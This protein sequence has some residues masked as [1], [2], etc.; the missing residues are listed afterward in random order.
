MALKFT[1]GEVPR[2]KAFQFADLAELTILV[3]RTS[4]VSKADLDSLIG[5]GSPDSDPDSDGESVDTDQSIDIAINHSK[6]TEDCFKQFSYRAGALDDHY[7]FALNNSL[8]T[9]KEN[10]TTSGYIYLFCLVCSRL[11][12]FSGQRGFAQRCAKAFTDLSSSAMR[13]V[14]KQSADVYVFD[15]GSKD[16]NLYFHTDLRQALKK[17]A[18][19]LNALPIHDVIDQQSASGDA[20]IDLI[21]INRMGDSA[22][23]VLAYFGQCA[24]QQNGWPK[25]TLETKRSAAFFHMAHAASNLLYTPV[26]YRNASGRWI[27]DAHSQDCIIIDRLRMM[28]A[29]EAAVHELSAGV[30]SEIRAVV[31]DA[32]NAITD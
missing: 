18:V 24:A 12:S 26:L 16:R 6:N 4:Q 29:L 32:A 10:V 21:A 25:K 11:A 28:R 1:V 17:L 9:A 23:G 13:A 14:L 19:Q 20:G 15:A 8:L 5:M 3:G 2:T 31:D 7:P 30:L 27:N 22:K